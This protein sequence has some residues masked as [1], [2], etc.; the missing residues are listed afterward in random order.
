MSIDKPLAICCDLDDCV[1]SFLGPFLDSYNNYNFKSVSLSD[2]Q[3][4]DFEPA[5]T[6]Y[7]HYVEVNGF[8]LDLPVEFGAITFIKKMKELGIFVIFITAR[9][10][11]FKRDTVLAL[12]KNKIVYDELFFSKNKVKTILQLKT[13]YDILGMIDDRFKTIKDVSLKCGLPFNFLI[14]KP[15]NESV[16]LRGSRVIRV[17][18]ILDIYKQMATRSLK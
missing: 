2:V 16:S 4:Y 18:Y 14:T 13:R 15:H 6:R 1:F 8:Y 5:L 10:E 11:Q 7:L 17:N 3:D 12:F 9:P